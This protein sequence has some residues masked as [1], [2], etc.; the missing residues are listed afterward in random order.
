MVCM[1]SRIGVI[2]ACALSL[3]AIKIPIGRP[4]T[5]ASTVQTEI[6]AMVAMVSSHMPK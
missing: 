2:S 4:I 1:T 3:R 6:M 5:T